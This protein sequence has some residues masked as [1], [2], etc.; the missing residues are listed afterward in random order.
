M[1]L[2]HPWDAH[3]IGRVVNGVP[4]VNEKSYPRLTQI[5]MVIAYGDDAITGRMETVTYTG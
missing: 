1:L 4:S 5:E 2:C 3:H